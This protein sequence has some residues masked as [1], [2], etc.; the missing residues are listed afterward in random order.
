M[1]RINVIL[2][3]L[4][5]V[6]SDFLQAQCPKEE[7]FFSTQEELESFKTKY[8]N[9]KS[10]TTSIHIDGLEIND[11]SPLSSVIQVKNLDILETSVK[12]LNGLENLKKVT[13]DIRIE[14][15]EYLTSVDKL[16]G[17]S[18]VLENFTIVANPL[19]TTIGINKIEKVNE[20]L[21]IQGNLKLQNIDNLKS[22]TTVTNE[23][24]VSD[25]LKL[26]T[27]QGLNGITGSVNKV[28][29]TINPMLTELNCFEKV[30]TINEK[31]VISNNVNLLNV[32]S[33]IGLTSVKGDV[34]IDKNPKLT[35]LAGLKN[36]AGS[37]NN[38]SITRNHSLSD[39]NAF[40]NLKVVNESLTISGSALKDLNSLI[41]LTNVKV[42]IAIQGNESLTNLD[43]LNNLEGMIGSVKI[44]KNINLE[45]IN[46][47]DKVNIIDGHLTISYND[48]L[49]TVSGFKNVESVS[50][51]VEIMKNPLLSIFYKMGDISKVANDIIINENHKNL[52]LPEEESEDNFDLDF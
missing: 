43:G 1:R 10:L 26:S 46:T 36:V 20:S 12:N 37:I 30:T 3:T 25:N 50:G 28:Q 9:C 8:A 31:I 27:L 5:V 29:I 4:L 34:L 47:F 23:I 40:A 15:N 41:K 44:N 7:L 19:L 32:N 42:Q 35:S 16:Q 38:I 13:G 14:F 39:L 48:A 22:I 49:T 52:K 33:L 6:F 2:F 51:N 17:V 11:L 45:E 24:V 18:G 21:V